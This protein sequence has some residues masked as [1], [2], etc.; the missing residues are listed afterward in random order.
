MSRSYKHT[1]YCGDTK[2][3]KM[4]RYANKKLRRQKLTHNYQHNSYKKE[5]CSWDICD[6]Y[7][8]Q[9]KNFN[10]YYQ[11]CVAR[12]YRYQNLWYMRDEPFPTREECWNEYQKWYIRK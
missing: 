8:I 10:N 1:P 12:W 3:R 5:T 2:D 4:K 6:Y 9:T 11:S 7:E